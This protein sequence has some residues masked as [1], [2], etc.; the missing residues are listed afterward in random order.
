MEL[1]FPVEV[2]DSIVENQFVD[3]RRQPS[4]PP[5]RQQVDQAGP[6]SVIWIDGKGTLNELVELGGVLQRRPRRPR[7]RRDGRASAPPAGQ[8]N[9]PVVVPCDQGNI[10]RAWHSA[11][12]H[13]L[14]LVQRAFAPGF[15]ELER[16]I[17]QRVNLGE[18]CEQR[19][20]VRATPRWP[21]RATRRPSSMNPRSSVLVFAVMRRTAERGSITKAAPMPG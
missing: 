21:G 5:M 7:R 2:M 13:H 9:G 4:R 16:T 15:V 18:P 17:E 19:G 8:F 3:A 1:S 12:Q 11:G 10:R 14:E 6:G 20:I